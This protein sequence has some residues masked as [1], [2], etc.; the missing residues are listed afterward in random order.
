MALRRLSPAAIAARIDAATATLSPVFSGDYVRWQRPAWWFRP[1]AG[2]AALRAAKL[3][4]THSRFE[5]VL[6]PAILYLHRL[7]QEGLGLKH[8]IN[9]SY[10]WAAKHGMDAVMQTIASNGYGHVALS[11]IVAVNLGPSDVIAHWLPGSR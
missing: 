10:M 1:V 2:V 7:L 4:V 3:V 9:V 5:G 11:D 8:V 6:W